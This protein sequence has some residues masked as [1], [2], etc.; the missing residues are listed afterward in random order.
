MSK[1][2]NTDTFFFEVL[3]S[4]NVIETL[5]EVSQK[6]KQG[7]EGVDAETVV[8]SQFSEI[9]KQAGSMRESELQEHSQK[10]I[11]TLARQPEEREECETDTEVD[12][13]VSTRTI[14]P[15]NL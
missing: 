4:Q 9:Q 1:S 11:A 6:Q 14:N 15:E 8:L 13:Q 2:Q 3:G 5:V 10:Q 12:K 7:R